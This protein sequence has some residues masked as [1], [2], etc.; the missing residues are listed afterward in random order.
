MS[1]ELINPQHSKFDNGRRTVCSDCYALGM[2][3]YE[4]IS[5]RVPFH[6]YAD[7]IVI[8]KVLAGER[9]SRGV[10]FA[11]SLWKMLEMCWALEPNDRPSVDGVLQRLEDI[12]NFSEPLSP[13]TDEEIDYDHGSSTGFSSSSS[14]SGYQSLPPGADSVRT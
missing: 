12:S 6:Q 1:P 5:G 3:I 14:S 7:L 9:P 2:V 10:G 4:I 13:G 8:V 11:E